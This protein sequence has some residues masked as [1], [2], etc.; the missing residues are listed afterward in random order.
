MEKLRL[1]GQVV[2]APLARCVRLANGRIEVA[3]PAVN[4][5][6]AVKEFLTHEDVGVLAVETDDASGQWALVVSSDSRQVLGYIFGEALLKAQRFQ[7]PLGDAFRFVFPRHTLVVEPR[8]AWWLRAALHHVTPEPRGA[9]GLPLRWVPGRG[10]ALALVRSHETQDAHESQGPPPLP[11]VEFAEAPAAGAPDEDAVRAVFLSLRLRLGLPEFPLD[12]RHGADNRRGFVAG[13][14]TIHASGRP[15][16]MCLVM[17]PNADLAEAT[18][19]LLHEF[20]HVADRNTT[21]DAAFKAALVELAAKEYGAPFFAQARRVADTSYRRVDMW[22]A[23]GVR[24]AMARRAA[25]TPRDADEGKLASIV[26]K[27]SKLWALADDQLGSPEAVTATATANGMIAAYDLGDYELALDDGIDDEM[28]DRW[29]SIGKRCVWKRRLAFAVAEFCGVFALVRTRE[30]VMHYFGTHADITSATYLYTY[31]VTRLEARADAHITQWK[32]Q[33]GSM[34]SGQTRKE[35]T[36]Y[37]DSAVLGLARV[38]EEQ[39]R[40]QGKEAGTRLDEA[41][42]FAAD[43]FDRRGLRWTSV[44]SKRVR[45]H[46]GGFAAGAEVGRQGTSGGRRLLSD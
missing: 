14:V 23:C 37:L 24:A 6:A 1:R 16:G 41:T 26:A 33:R 8:Y 35:R 7:H 27:V 42:G 13:R 2:A 19:T 34:K 39:T 18:A 30:G 36:S 5:V 9:D 11:D 20:A 44:S 32:R 3:L 29:V 28:V 31:C 40:A 4:A 17:C 21:H 38:L 45:F 25:P 43:Q 46:E 12:I 15:L 10:R 22:V